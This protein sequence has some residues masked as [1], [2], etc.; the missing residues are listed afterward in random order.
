M[1]MVPLNSCLAQ[2]LFIDLPLRM[3]SPFHALLTGPL[4]GVQLFL[5]TRAWYFTLPIELGSQAHT[6]ALSTAK[7]RIRPARS[8]DL[9]VASVRK[10]LEDVQTMRWGSGYIADA[11]HRSRLALL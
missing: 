3:Y 1:T 5:S 2:R 8:V 7:D 10:L 11:G 4:G 9:R 6:N